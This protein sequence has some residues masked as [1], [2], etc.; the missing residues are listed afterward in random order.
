MEGRDLLV[1]ELPVYS[2]DQLREHM[3]EG[4]FNQN[5]E[6]EL[7]HPKCGFCNQYFFNLARF[8]KH[9]K[10]NHEVCHVCGKDH[11]HR[12]YRDYETLNQHFEQTHFTCRW[13][14][15]LDKGFVVFRT[16]EEREFHY[17]REF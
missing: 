4:V 10:K 14:S 3:E 2:R 1:S 16:E 12:Y 17:V 13:K 7:F 11:P 8:V 5:G 6:V 15:C 9:M